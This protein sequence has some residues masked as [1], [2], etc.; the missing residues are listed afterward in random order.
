VI[1]EQV[2]QIEKLKEDLERFHDKSQC[3]VIEER[4]GNVIPIQSLARNQRTKGD[5]RRR[6]FK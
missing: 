2:K 6:K 3:Q 4:I 5:R 1:A